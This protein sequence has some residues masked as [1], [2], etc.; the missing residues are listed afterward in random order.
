MDFTI[1]A[2]VITLGVMGLLFGGGLAY[3][4]MKFAVKIDPRVEMIRNILPGANCGGCG[5]PGCSGYAEAVVQGN[6]PPTLC[7]PGGSTTVEKIAS[8]LGVEVGKFE[9]MVCVVQCRGGKKEAKEKFVYYGI[10]DCN[11]AVLLGGGSKACIYGCLGLGS[12]EEA[13][14]YNAI[15]INENRIP[16]VDED[17]CTGC[18]LCVSAC[19]KGITKLVPRSQK[20][21]VSCVNKERGKKVKD[22]CSVGCTGCTLCANPKTTPSGKV[23]MEDNLP[24]IPSDWIDYETAVKKCP[25]KCLIVRGIP[26]LEETVEKVAEQKN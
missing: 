6:A 23:K 5:Y 9:P 15:K 18:G 10:K 1:I 3:A 26:Q 21:Y 22:V 25:A 11:A 13:C 8:I 7:S 16:V 2:S 14:P 17:L 19:P 20:V 24:V 4:S 12:C